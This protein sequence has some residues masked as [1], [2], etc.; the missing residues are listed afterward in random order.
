MHST[1]FISTDLL[2]HWLWLLPLLWMLL[3]MVVVV[4]L[5]FSLL[6]GQLTVLAGCLF[7]ISAKPAR[8]C[9]LQTIFFSF[10]CILC[11]FEAS[12]S[13]RT[14][15]EYAIYAAI[16]KRKWLLPRIII[17]HHERGELRS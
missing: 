13:P 1:C 9:M 3:W 12:K 2:A 10:V 4:V 17:V 8:N 16:C 14:L 5:L 11:I 15:I 7:G 6:F